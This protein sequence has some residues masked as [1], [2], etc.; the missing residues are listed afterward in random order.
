[1]QACLSDTAMSSCVSFRNNNLLRSIVSAAGPE[2][3]FYTLTGWV[4]W[5]PEI[6]I[7]LLTKSHLLCRNMLQ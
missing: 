1:V 7:F 4:G 5:K 6:Q 2:T 3:V